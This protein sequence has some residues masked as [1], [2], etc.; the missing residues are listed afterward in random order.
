MEKIIIGGIVIAVIVVIIILILVKTREHYNGYLPIWHWTA[1][2][3]KNQ[4]ADK[5]TMKPG[6]YFTPGS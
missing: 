2:D 3:K 6:K 4:P 1:L 5:C